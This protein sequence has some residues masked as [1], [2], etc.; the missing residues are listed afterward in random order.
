MHVFCSVFDTSRCYR[1][2]ER[3]TLAPLSASNRSMLLSSIKI[4]VF[5]S[6]ATRLQIDLNL[7]IVNCR[8]KCKSRWSDYCSTCLIRKYRFER[9]L[10]LVY[11]KH[12]YKM[13]EKKRAGDERQCCGGGK[14]KRAV[15]IT[16]RLK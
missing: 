6:L 13:Y 11:G 4:L 9:Q 1:E 2:V 10:P 7:I 16:H 8:L 15:Y 5:C 14:Q 12:R 3:N